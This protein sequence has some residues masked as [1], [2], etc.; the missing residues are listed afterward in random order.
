MSEAVPLSLLR[1]AG[2]Y[3]PDSDSDQ[4]PADPDD[5]VGPAGPGGGDSEERGAVGEGSEGGGEGRGET[6]REAV[7][8]V[9]L[10]ALH[11]MPQ[12]RPYGSPAHPPT[13]A[14]TCTHDCIQH[15]YACRNAHA[16][17]RTHAKAIATSA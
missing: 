16:R 12:N 14:R 11:K 8:R 17:A 10:A 6:G 4:H 15:M 5:R 7:E 3:G 1:D 9:L 2:F 13:N